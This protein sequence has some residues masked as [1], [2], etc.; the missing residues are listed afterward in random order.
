MVNIQQFQSRSAF[1]LEESVHS[2]M[3]YAHQGSW[4][5]F[6]IYNH[7]YRGTA[8]ATP[9]ADRFACGAAPAGGRGR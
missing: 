1:D 7:L 6:D 4:Y 2:L 5:P 9:I 8:Q 3:S